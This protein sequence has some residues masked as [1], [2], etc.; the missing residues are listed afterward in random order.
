MNPTLVMSMHLVSTIPCSNCIYI[1]CGL[2]ITLM[3]FVA[4]RLALA[5]LCCMSGVTTI[6]QVCPQTLDL[7]QARLGRKSRQQIYNI[8]APQ[9]S[10]PGLVLL[11][12]IGERL[13]S[14]LRNTRVQR[15]IRMQKLW[16]NIRLVGGNAH[17]VAIHIQWFGCY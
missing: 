15:K 2:V 16:T 13:D 1:F 4:Y 3:T 12:E 9:E 6:L 17:L 10:E 5:H 14:V 11:L 7:V 8:V